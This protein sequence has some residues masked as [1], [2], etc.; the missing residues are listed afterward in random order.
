[1]FLTPT[2]FRSDAAHHAYR[3]YD[4]WGKVLTKEPKHAAELRVEGKQY[5][6][7]LVTH[8]QHPEVAPVKR[9][10]SAT[11]EFSITVSG[12]QLHSRLSASGPLLTVAIKGPELMTQLAS[13]AHEPPADAERFATAFLVAVH[14]REVSMVGVSRAA[15]ACWAQLLLKDCVY[16][17]ARMK[18]VPSSPERPISWSAYL[19]PNTLCVHR[20]G[21]KQASKTHT[22]ALKLTPNV[23]ERTPAGHVLLY[24]AHLGLDT[25]LLLHMDAG[26]LGLMNLLVYRNGGQFVHSPQLLPTGV[27]I[28]CLDSL[29]WFTAQAWAQM[30]HHKDFASKL[31]KSDNVFTRRNELDRYREALL[32]KE[33]FVPRCYLHEF[34]A[35]APIGHRVQIDKDHEVATVS[36]VTP[37]ELK[38]ASELFFQQVVKSNRGIIDFTKGAQ[39]MFEPFDRDAWRQHIPNKKDE[40]VSLTVTVDLLYVPLMSWLDTRVASAVDKEFDEEEEEKGA[41]TADEEE[42]SAEAAAAVAAG[43]DDDDDD[44]TLVPDDDDVEDVATTQ[45]VL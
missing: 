6:M 8:D 39:M 40:L 7:K 22:Y 19:R 37:A 36:P 20:Q 16:D 2:Y 5:T 43:A 13:L 24:N 21:Q 14:L 42:T 23:T 28:T 34:D 27:D 33:Q 41:D 26:T 30:Y 35:Q 38:V 29:A 31:Q 44:T 9:T 1:M 25:R 45:K 18:I 11:L 4:A 32:R 12:D 3:N 15:G 10:R 17:E